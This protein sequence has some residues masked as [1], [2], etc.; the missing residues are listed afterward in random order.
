M[1]SL[2]ETVPQIVAGKKSRSM[3]FRGVAFALVA[4]LLCAGYLL[5]QQQN[6][7]VTPSDLLTQSAPEQMKKV[8]PA[9]HDVANELTNIESSLDKDLDTTEIGRE[10]DEVIQ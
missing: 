4:F 1:S 3:V 7:E 2:S 6:K 9:V 10:I 8:D 5:W